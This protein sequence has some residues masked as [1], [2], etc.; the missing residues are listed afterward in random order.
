MV[1]CSE[2][3]LAYATNMQCGQCVAQNCMALLMA[4]TNCPLRV[5]QL[6]GCP[7]CSAT[8]FARGHGCPRRGAVTRPSRS[9]ARRVRRPAGW[10]RARGVCRGPRGS[11]A[12]AGLWRRRAVGT[13][14]ARSNRRSGRCGRARRR[15]RCGIEPADAARERSALRV[16]ARSGL[17]GRRA[18]SRSE[19]GRR[20]RWSWPRTDSGTF[21]RV[22]ATTGA[23]S[24]VTAPG[25]SARAARPGR[26]R[27]SPTGAAPTSR[28]RSTRA[29]RAR[30]ALSGLC[31]R[32]TAPLHGILSRRD[33]GRLDRGARSG[34]LP[35]RRV[36]RRRRGSLHAAAAAAYA[37]GG[38]QRVLF[39][40]GLKFRVEPATGRAT[41]RNAG[42]PARVVLGKLP[43]TGQFI[44]WYNGP[45]AAETKAQLD[46]L[47]EDDPR[48]SE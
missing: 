25:S 2:G 19:P 42:V 38:G 28:A 31:R 6:S 29:S 5:L 12:G 9:L 4:C 32:R 43:E 14:P 39:A 48:W 41:P 15:R 3:Q 27:P 11:G 22:F 23:R 13:G 30:R 21:R 44:H 7:A 34:A 37:R 8:C 35:A 10:V 40:C 26:T 18:R 20:G 36:D 16:A 24:S 45:V 46:W 17:S 33:P 1:G 47:L